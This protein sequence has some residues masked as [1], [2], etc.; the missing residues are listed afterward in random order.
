MSHDGK[1]NPMGPMKIC[2]D[3]AYAARMAGTGA[4]LNAKED[5]Q[6]S[7]SRGLDGSYA[8]SATCKK[9]GQGVV[10]SKGT[11]R[12]D[13][14]STYNVHIENDISGAAISAIN[15]HHVMDINA[16]YVGACPPGMAGGDMVLPNGMTVNAGKMMGGDAM[17]GR[18]PPRPGA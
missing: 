4:R 16:T 14:S 2:F 13:F 11:I 5:C 1:S 10:T 7:F 17:P 18:G 12:G 9:P 15:G 6:Q 8:F 3:D